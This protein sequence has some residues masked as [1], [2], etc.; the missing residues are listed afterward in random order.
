MLAQFSIFTFTLIQTYHIYLL[1]LYPRKDVTK[2]RSRNQM[3]F[4]LQRFG[5]MP[6]KE[7]HNL[8]I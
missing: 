3:L 7:I 2:N 4:P 6:F 5:E 8:V 1:L